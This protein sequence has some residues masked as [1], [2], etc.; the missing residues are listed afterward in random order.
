MEIL[1][2]IYNYI[3]NLLFPKNYRQFARGCFRTSKQVGEI[4]FELPPYE[5]GLQF[6][7][8][9]RP[10]NDP[11]EFYNLDLC[12]QDEKTWNGFL[13]GS[14]CKI[15]D[16]HYWTEWNLTETSTK[17]TGTFI[18]HKDGKSLHGEFSCEYE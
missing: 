6:D 3:Y 16:G 8:S 12:W 15:V 18:I 11:E 13:E 10:L 17:L 2:S 1:S 9:I 7:G 5:K 14:T 4:A